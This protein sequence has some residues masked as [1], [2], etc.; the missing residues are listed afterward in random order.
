ML[1][2]SLSLYAFMYVYFQI[3]NLYIP[4]IIL[5]FRRN[6]ISFVLILLTPKSHF[7]TFLPLVSGGRGF[8]HSSR[9]KFSVRVKLLSK[10]IVQFLCKKFAERGSFSKQP[11]KKWAEDLNTHFSK[12]DIQMAN[13]LD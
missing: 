4:E 11:I 3:M 8:P 9:T 12:E 10:H 7:P 13:R 5:S 6:H 2:L 1:T